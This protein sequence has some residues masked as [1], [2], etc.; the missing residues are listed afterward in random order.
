VNA[1]DVAH[2]EVAAAEVAPNAAFAVITPGVEV[3]PDAVAVA[4]ELDGAG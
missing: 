4:A 1:S 2:A 3:S